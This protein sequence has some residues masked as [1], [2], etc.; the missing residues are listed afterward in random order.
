[1]YSVP[2]YKASL[3]IGSPIYI[4]IHTY[5]WIEKA[6]IAGGSFYRASIY[7]G[8]FIYIYIYLYRAPVYTGPIYRVLLSAHFAFSR[9]SPPDHSASPSVSSPLIPPP[10]SAYPSST[11]SS[12]LPLLSSFS[13]HG[14][15][16]TC[17]LFLCTLGY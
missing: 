3:Y 2:M 12:P 6:P 17:P 8:L 10:L 15:L 16:Y 7:R 9:T 1:M 11:S 14:A 4:Y 13:I 5:F